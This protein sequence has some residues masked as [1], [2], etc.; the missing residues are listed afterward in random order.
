MLRFFKS[1]EPDPKQLAR[2]LFEKVAALSSRGHEARTARLRVGMLVRTFA[3]KSFVAGAQQ[4]AQW[5]EA[6]DQALVQGL[7]KPAA[8]EASAYLEIKSGGRNLWV[9]LPLP[10]AQAFFDL[11][12]RYQCM[13]INAHESITQA[14]ALMDR[15]CME[16]LQIETP[17]E[18]LQFLRQELQD[19]AARAAGAAAPAELSAPGESGLLA[20]DS[21]PARLSQP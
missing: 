4:A 15:I 17:F 6:V 12:A 14:Q 13:Q 10:H 1:A 20:E 7:E 16:E 19:A 21:A 9:Y 5:Q 3:D 8:P 2:Q 18:V 11:G